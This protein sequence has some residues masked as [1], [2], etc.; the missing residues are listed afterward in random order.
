MTEFTRFLNF[1]FS[2]PECA[3]SLTLFAHKIKLNY[4]YSNAYN[5]TRPDVSEAVLAFRDKKIYIYILKKQWL[6][7]P[8]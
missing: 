4:M 2:Q 5:Y 7:I 8:A 1:H 3:I 6:F